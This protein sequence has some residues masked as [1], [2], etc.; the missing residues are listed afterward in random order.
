MVVFHPRHAARTRRAHRP[1]AGA[2]PLTFR[3][4]RAA[5]LRGVRQRRASKALAVVFLGLFAI[6][7]LGF[8]DDVL[9]VA[10]SQNEIRGATDRLDDFVL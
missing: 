7:S 6:P 4:C 8:A 9:P 10:V 1:P 2:A 5:E 3:P